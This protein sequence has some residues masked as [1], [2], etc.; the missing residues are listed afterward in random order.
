[1]DKKTRIAL[2]QSIEKWK[3][4]VENAKHALNNDMKVVRDSSAFKDLN[5]YVE[6]Y[7]SSEACPLCELYNS[8]LA[9]SRGLECHGCPIFKFTGHL[10]CGET[11]YEKVC[12]HVKRYE[13]RLATQILVDACQAEVDF[14]QA[15]LRHRQ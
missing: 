4:N 12:E 5:T 9:A 8:A 14:L 3:G 13:P 2:E 7:T 15:L 1:M 11:P 10:S 6:I